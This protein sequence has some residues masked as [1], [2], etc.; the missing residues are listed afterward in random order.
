MDTLQ[1]VQL[2]DTVPFKLGPGTIDYFTKWPEAI[3]V[4]DKSASTTARVLEDEVFSRFSALE[5]LHS[6]W[7]R[8]F[9]ADVFNLVCEHLGVKKTR[10]APPHPQSDSLV[11][12]FNLTLTTQLVM[13]TNKRQKD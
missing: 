3:A 11:E 10:T 1:C 2:E 5:E 7:R 4:P 13:L 9:E 8:N 12:R 6:D